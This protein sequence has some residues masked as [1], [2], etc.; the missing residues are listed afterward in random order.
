MSNPKSDS[1]NKV[2]QV[3]R[4]KSMKVNEVRKPRKPPLQAPYNF[5]P[6]YPEVFEAY[7]SPQDPPDPR[8][9]SDELITGEISYSVL[10]KSPIVFEKGTS[11]LT[12]S[13]MRGLVR[14]NLQILS[15]S[16]VD[17]DIED[18]IF[19]YRDY[20][21]A[22]FNKVLGQHI[23]TKKRGSSVTSYSEYGN[24]HAGIMYKDNNVWYIKP[25]S[26][27]K[28]K[29]CTILNLQE[30]QSKYK[31]WRQRYKVSYKG[32]K[33]V[34]EL[35]ESKYVDKAARNQKTVH[36]PFIKKISFEYGENGNFKSIGEEGIYEKS[37]YLINTGS[38]YGSVSM[39]LIPCDSTFFKE[40]AF[41][42]TDEDISNYIK[43]L[44]K[45]RIITENSYN[46]FYE[47]NEEGEKPVFYIKGKQHVEFGFT[48]VFP[49]QFQH[50]VKFGIPDSHKKGKID[51]NKA[52]FGFHGLKN[53][54]SGRMFNYGGRVVFLEPYRDTDSAGY[55][56]DIMLPNPRP[57]SNAFYTHNDK[58]DRY[59][60]DQFSINGIK[61][62]RMRYGISTIENGIDP[63]LNTSVNGD[64]IGTRY[65]GKVL[66]YNLR[67][68]ELGLLIWSIRLNNGCYQNIGAGKQYG[69]GRVE[70]SVT[71]IKQYLY[72]PVLTSEDL[73]QLPESKPLEQDYY[74]KT[75]WSRLN[76]F[77]NRRFEENRIIRDFFTMKS[78]R[79]FS[80][81]EDPVYDSRR[82][83]YSKR[84]SKLP[85]VESLF[86]KQKRLHIPGLDNENIKGYTWE[87]FIQSPPPE[88]INMTQQMQI[89]NAYKEL[90]EIIELYNNNH[91]CF[92]R[93][94][95]LKEFKEI[96]DRVPEN[97]KREEKTDLV[98]ENEAIE[99]NI[100][101]C[102]D[103]IKFLKAIMKDYESRLQDESI[104]ILTSIVTRAVA[105]TDEKKLY[106]TIQLA[107]SESSALIKVNHFQLTDQRNKQYK[108]DFKTFIAG[109]EKDERDFVIRVD[110]D[111]IDRSYVE[112]KL[113]VD[114][115]YR[116]GN[117]QKTADYNS[118]IEIPFTKEQF[119]VLENPYS[120]WLGN[121][122]SDRKMFFGRDE[123]LKEIRDK[124]ASCS[125]NHPSGRN[126][127]IYGQKRTGKSTLLH[128][129]KEDLRITKPN[130][131]VVVDV[132]NVGSVLQLNSENVATETVNLRLF[133]RKLID[134]TV[135]ELEH[136]HEDLF[137]DLLDEGFEFPELK[138]GTH[139]E[140]MDIC[141]NFFIKLTERLKP[142]K[143]VV[144]LIDE[145]TYFYDLIEKE[146]VDGYFMQFWKA[147][148]QNSKV[149]VVMSGQD[150][151][152]DFRNRFANEFGA[153]DV[154]RISYLDRES[155][156]NLIRK[157]FHDNNG[158]DGFSDE[159]VGKLLSLTACS[160]FY[161]MYICSALVDYLNE[162]KLWKIV[163]PRVVERFLQ[164]HWM[165][166]D[167]TKRVDRSFFEALYNDG[168]HPEWGNDNLQILHEIAELDRGSGAGKEEVVHSLTNNNGRG[169]RT[170]SYCRD[171][172]QRL[173]YR[174]VINEKNGKIRIRV[175]LLQRWLE[176]VY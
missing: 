37:A 109:G 87:Q 122:V 153:S 39:Y 98:A 95:L 89:Y 126:I 83:Y 11:S 43:Y 167:S 34:F 156:I 71:D 111:D 99:E 91:R 54:D 2:P 62:Y 146:Y 36:D 65:Q 55:E 79:S 100:N 12:A 93:E 26:A 90:V 137:E 114:Y 175:G 67:E 115:Q 15:F 56:T 149:C 132:G 118:Q 130:N 41:P 14:S 103:E 47:L 50:S 107:L 168:T 135:A 120:S 151:M 144:I 127:I 53:G 150:F 174:D 73:M 173:I 94:E 78:S 138:E 76:G 81:V 159:C 13:M 49:I 134:V 96:C 104:P 72:K 7:K 119:Q 4:R 158:Y 31:N 166:P 57:S 23:V 28:G 117:S 22:Y 69:Y 48:Y 124:I 21:D 113:R 106:L 171:K 68:D 160:A 121:E 30:M 101:K 8:K 18:V 10:S 140:A 74:V 152:N 84:S 6:L 86:G 61:Q 16:S 164:E 108:Q 46:G 129:L 5:I 59:N 19:K 60:S 45:Q 125:G 161:T 77:L 44:R 139:A 141:E 145:F 24:I 176:D 92:I 20:S 82:N 172:I 155:A 25:S 38:M 40:D 52:I 63:S 9:I 133:F 110:D 102:I 64:E 131:Y 142:D 163:T 123:M 33:N 29:G 35:F 1:V 75:Y 32:Y 154:M 105:N 17:S 51:Y 85:S 162:K 165:N 136:E 80:R 58:Y 169:R 42:V 148:V 128:F 88:M 170:I 116:S 66:F 147:F 157:P 27:F 70:I 3:N 143:R 112:L 97:M